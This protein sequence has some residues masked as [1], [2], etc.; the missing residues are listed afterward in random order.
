MF[1]SVEIAE[2][3]S[4]SRS[5]PDSP[6]LFELLLERRASSASACVDAKRTIGLVDA[7]VRAPGARRPGSARRD[8]LV[9]SGSRATLAAIGSRKN[10]GLR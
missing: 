1:D 9:A 4:S 3:G 8:L 5:S 10:G 7:S 6:A 2:L